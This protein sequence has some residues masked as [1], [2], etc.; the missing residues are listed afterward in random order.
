M[1]KSTLRKLPPISREIAKLAN[2]V[3]SIG[4]RL[5]NLALRINDKEMEARFS[6]VE[7]PD[8]PVGE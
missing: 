2:E 5:K 3:S 1:R 7:K 8:R 6:G 4:R